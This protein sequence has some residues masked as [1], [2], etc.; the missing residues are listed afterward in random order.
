MTK[1]V[2]GTGVNIALCALKFVEMYRPS[3]RCVY[4]LKVGAPVGPD[5]Y[6]VNRQREW[7]VVSILQDLVLT[8][9]RASDL[10]VSQVPRRCI[11]YLKSRAFYRALG[12]RRFYGGLMSPLVPRSTDRSSRQAQLSPWAT[13]PCLHASRLP[14]C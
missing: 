9:T 7:S 10:P 3:S 6:W 11:G 2:F 5:R 4:D 8:D 14:G 13:L 1:K 12:S